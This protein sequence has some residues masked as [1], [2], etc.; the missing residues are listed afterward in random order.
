LGG[1]ILEDLAVDMV[2]QLLDID[3]IVSCLGR[4]WASSARVILIQQ[5][6]CT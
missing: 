1:A 2:T 6:I 4:D 3:L 5:A